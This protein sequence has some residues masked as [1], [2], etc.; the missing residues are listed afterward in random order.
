MRDSYPY[1]RVLIY[2]ETIWDPLAKALVNWLG[3][4]YITD[5]QEDIFHCPAAGLYDVLC[6]S[7]CGQGCLELCRAI[8]SNEAIR[9]FPVVVLSDSEAGEAANYLKAGAEAF[10]FNPDRDLFLSQISSILNNRRFVEDALSRP[11][12][13]SRA[14]F[15]SRD[16]A[17]ISRL[18]NFI[19]ANIQEPN[20]PVSRLASAMNMSPSNLFRRVRE[21]LGKSP[22]ALVNEMRLSKAKEILDKNEKDIA[23]IVFLT[24]FNSHSYFSKCF[25]R[26]FGMSPSEYLSK[27]VSGIAAK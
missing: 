6:L 18:Q 19:S 3:G 25:K 12:A 8:K 26:R 9:H 22:N 27:D 16:S 2:S 15:N 24:G 1:G 11:A 21:V 10:L 20:L 17:F 13:V 7:A 14:S 4:A 5:N 23:E